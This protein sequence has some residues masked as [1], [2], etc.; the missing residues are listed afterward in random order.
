MQGADPR[1]RNFRVVFLLLLV[2]GVSALFVAVA[3]PFLK[4]LLL[5]GLLAG[6]CRPFYGRVAHLLGDRRS[7]AA[8]VTL[9]VL[10]ALVAG[11]LSAFL[12]IVVREAV[13]VSDQAIPW[14]QNHFGATSTFDIHDWLARRFPRLADYIPSQDQLMENFGT[15]AKSAGGLLVAAASRMTSGTAAFLLNGFV[16]VYALFFFL[17]DGEKIMEKIF[18]YMPL[19]HEDEERM[20]DQLTSITRATLKGTIVVGIVQGA[21]IGFAFWLAGIS[22]AAFWGTVMALLSMLPIVGA[23]LVWVPAI[24]YLFVT[25]Q[26]FAGILLSAWCA[27]VVGVID[28][29]LRS[30]LVGSDAKIPDLLI[31][32]GTLGGLFLFG[33]IGFIV[34]PIV[35]GLFLTVWDI[36]GVTFKEIL[37]PT[38]M[39]RGK[40][41]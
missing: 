29:V 28:N 4:T 1:T 19:N 13:Y 21:L 33:P 11:P 30:V 8:I 18:Y 22:S 24:V 32:V 40:H 39:R 25:G 26:I 12:S 14:V 9:I 36:Y 34:G 35:C 6:I 16:M 10:F 7:L 15:A 20:L 3:W 37:P 41:N 38:R 5:A 2:I 17:R 31:L 23:P 27:A